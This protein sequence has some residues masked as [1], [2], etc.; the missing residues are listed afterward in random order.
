LKEDIKAVKSFP[1]AL[2]LFYFFRHPHGKRFGYDLLNVRWKRA[3]K[4]LGVEGVPVYP[5]SK[6]STLTELMKLH[7]DDVAK[8]ASGQAT[9]KARDRY[10]LTNQ[11]DMRGIY[12]QCGT[13]KADAP[14]TLEKGVSRK[15]KVVKFIKD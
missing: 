10:I 9:N 14:L 2:P 13:G 3:Y 5:G 4:N 7:G 6:H 15:G 11:N 12:A 1:L 8:Q